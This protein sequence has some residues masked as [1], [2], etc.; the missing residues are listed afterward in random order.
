MKKIY[1]VTKIGEK[2]FCNYKILNSVVLPDTLKEIGALAFQDCVY[3][4]NLTLPNSVALIG[5]NAFISCARL[6]IYCSLKPITYVCSSV[7]FI[8]INVH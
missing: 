1:N 8:N 3:L 6:T 2:A 4:K 5:K 7:Y